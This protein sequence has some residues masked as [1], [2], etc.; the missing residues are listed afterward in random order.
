MRTFSRLGILA[1]TI[2]AGVSC[3]D[4]TDLATSATG[5]GNN[6]TTSSGASGGMGSGGMGAGATGGN[7][8]G[9]QGGSVA[10][11]LKAFPSAY[12]AGAYITGGRGGTVIPVTRLDDARNDDDSPVEGTLRYALTQRFPRTVVFRVSGTIV[13]GDTNGDGVLDDGDS[14]YPGM[15]SIDSPDMSDLTVAGQTAPEGGISIRGHIWLA[16]PSNIVWR[17]VRIRKNAQDGSL[18]DAFVGRAPQ[19]IVMDHISVAYG[20]DEGLTITDA[21]AQTGITMQ[22]CLIAASKTGSIIGNVAADGVEA[23]VHNNFFTQ[24]SHRFPNVAGGGRFDVINN[25]TYNWDDRLVS[26]HNAA[27]VN[28]IANAYV[29]GAE[30]LPRA[31]YDT[32]LGKINVSSDNYEQARIYSA[33]NF[34]SQV[35]TDPNADDWS[36]WTTFPTIPGL[37]NGSPAPMSHKVSTPY[38]LLGSK[39]TIRSVGDIQSDLPDEVGAFRTLDE[40]GA[41]VVYRDSLDEQY[42]GD[43]RNDT[44]PTHTLDQSTFTYPNLPSNSPYPDGDADGMPDAWETA[45]GFDPN[46]DDSA[47]DAD[48]DGYTNLEEFLNLVDA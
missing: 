42:I 20:T 34:I 13:V 4:D 23:S 6:S 18:F 30:T 37:P 9:G 12:G 10:Q 2:L 38:E 39:L 24:T 3:S 28:H 27:L 32:N 40:N 48:G 1:A 19:D 36:L 21:G 5:G 16:G 25:L 11:E 46:V 8:S 17:Y 43:Y 47:G 45:N 22:N 44:G 7:G 15:I 35:L 33:G 31:P 26:V 14:T 41:I 29:E